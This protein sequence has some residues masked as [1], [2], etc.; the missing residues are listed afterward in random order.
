MINISIKFLWLLIGVFIV[1]CLG[2]YVFLPWCFFFVIFVNVSQFSYL[3]FTNFNDYNASWDS[4]FV[5]ADFNIDNDVDGLEKNNNVSSNDL[6]LVFY[7]LLLFFTSNVKTFVNI[8]TMF[9][10]YKQIKTRNHDGKS[11]CIRYQFFTSDFI[12]TCEDIQSL[13]TQQTIDH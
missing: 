13:M 8:Y 4:I 3:F 2:L 9:S 11:T 7:T 6:W 12:D 5:L 1:L 10:L